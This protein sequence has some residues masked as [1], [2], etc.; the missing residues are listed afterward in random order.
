M[1]ILDGYAAARAIR[2]LADPVKSN[3]RIIALTASVSANL[4]EKTKAAGMN[5]YI[6]KP[7]KIKELY[8]KLANVDPVS[9]L[10]I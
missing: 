6:L 8:Q 10:Q 9:S 3:V 7:F 5:D 2:E 1:P 4:D